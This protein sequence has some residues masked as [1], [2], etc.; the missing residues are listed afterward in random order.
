MKRFLLI[1]ISLIVQLPLS[2]QQRMI[3]KPDGRLNPVTKGSINREIR[4]IDKHKV[5]GTGNSTLD[6]SRNNFN[7][8]PGDIDTL[9]LPGPSWASNQFVFYSQEWLLQWLQCPT[10]L[11]LKKVGFSCGIG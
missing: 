3:L 4:Y 8:P 9:R 2:A 6:Y 1:I 11:I 10:D 5:S 7:S